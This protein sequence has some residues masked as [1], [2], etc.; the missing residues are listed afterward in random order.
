MS[1]KLLITGGAGFIGVNAAKYF[2]QQGW[3]IIV[4]DN[5]SRK[6][7]QNNLN[8]LQGI[9]NFDFING[10]I[11]ERQLVEQVFK[12]YSIDAILHLAAQVAVT[13]SVVD[14]RDDFEINAIGTF[15]L[16]EAA[17]LFAPEAPFI[18]A[19]TNKVYGK[20][21]D[22]IV[23]ERSGRYEY[24]EKTNGIAENYPLDFHSPYGCSK[25]AGDQYVI[26]YN[27][28]YGLPTTSFRQSCIYGPRQFG[29]EDQGWVAWLAIA[30]FLGRHITIYGDGKQIR[31]ILH[32]NDLIHAYELAIENPDNIAGRAFNIG[33][34]PDN[35]LSLLELIAIL[36]GRLGRKIPFSYDQWRAGDQKVFVCNVDKAESNLGWKSEID[37]ATGVNRLYDW[38]KANCDL[39]KNVL[40]A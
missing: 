5:L 12:E 39:L 26:D 21:E 23:T 17:R 22:V 36:E 40:V 32:V 1:K 11:R 20:M 25:G 7:A 28:I 6:G 19:S 15:N 30:S 38:I 2:V 34:G 13:T 31:D 10:D 3:D 18:Y 37:V 24:L 29:V 8:W 4:L 35:T 33:G 9:I 14:P 16:L 27:R